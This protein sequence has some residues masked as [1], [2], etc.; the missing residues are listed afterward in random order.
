MSFAP[1]LYSLPFE[2]QASAAVSD[3]ESC[4]RCT[5]SVQRLTELRFPE[6]H[7]PSGTPLALIQD[8]KGRYWVTLINQVPLVF[9]SG[10]EFVASVG[11]KGR[12]PGEFE[13]PVGGF[14]VPGDSIVIVDQV[15]RRA[16]VVAPDLTAARYVALRWTPPS[17]GDAMSVASWPENVITSMQVRTPQAVGFPLQRM[18]FGGSDAEFIRAFGP[19]S[20]DAKPPLNPLQWQNHLSHVVG[21]HFWSVSWTDYTLY[22]WLT[23]GTLTSA[24][25]RR[26]SWFPDTSTIGPFYSNVP[27]PSLVSGV[28]EDS[29]GLLWVAVRIPALNWQ[30]A[31]H[32]TAFP[33]RAGSP[34]DM[35]TYKLWRTV[36]EVVDP[37][38][39]RVVH[40]L[41]MNELVFTIL[42]GRRIALYSEDEA[43]LPH[44][45][46]AKLSLSGYQRFPLR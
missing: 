23:D 15:N 46:I 13:L 38:S 30:K 43:G 26:P 21:N 20:G 28:I 2:G 41:L 42:P 5:I 32:T 33:H 27:P 4:P 16:T 9:G 34:A 35:D 31:W 44:I 29:T 24:L 6:S 8:G 12:G 11:S 1:V 17:T 37:K 36:I 14:R 10:G 40:R 19:G 45:R 7:T 18:N 39:A 25:R 3:A 22:R